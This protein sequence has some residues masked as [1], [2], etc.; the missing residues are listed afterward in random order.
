M[1]TNIKVP[2]TPVTIKLAP[3]NLVYNPKGPTAKETIFAATHEVIS[4]INTYLYLHDHGHQ[5]P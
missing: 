4:A 1:I 3:L 5:S 2:S